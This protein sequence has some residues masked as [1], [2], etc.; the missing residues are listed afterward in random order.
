MIPYSYSIFESEKAAKDFMAACQLFPI[1]LKPPHYISEEFAEKILEIS[2][3]QFA[4][5]TRNGLS[6]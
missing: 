4:Q 5:Y 1:N 6:S 2:M 3:Q